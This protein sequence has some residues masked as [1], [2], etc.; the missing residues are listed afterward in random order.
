M[1]FIEA[2]SGTAPVWL[3]EHPTWEQVLEVIAAIDGER[4]STMTMGANQVDPP[5]LQLC[6]GDDGLVMCQYLWDDLDGFK[7]LQ[8]PAGDPAER[9]RLTIG[10]QTGDNWSMDAVHP[11][12]AV[13]PCVRHFYEH[14]TVNNE[15]PWEESPLGEAM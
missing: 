13:I 5:W 4:Y 2:A 7:I 1:N 14:G 9:V 3:I 15:L 8:N 10:G 6:G 11:V 12:S